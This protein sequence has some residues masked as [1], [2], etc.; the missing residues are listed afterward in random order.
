M[1]Y[2]FSTVYNVIYADGAELG[3]YEY[4]HTSPFIFPN[5]FYDHNG[6]CYINGKLLSS[7]GL[8]S[9]YIFVYS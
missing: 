3:D 7:I 5:G 9:T 2:V 1:Y 8:I 4:E 6:M